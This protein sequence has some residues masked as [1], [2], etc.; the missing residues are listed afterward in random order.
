MECY[1][2]GLRLHS[3][4]SLTLHLEGPRTSKLTVI[5]KFLPLWHVRSEPNWYSRS[6]VVRS[7]LVSMAFCVESHFAAPTFHWPLPHR[8]AWHFHANGTSP[9]FIQSSIFVT[10]FLSQRSLRHIPSATQAGQRCCGTATFAT[11]TPLI[12]RKWRFNRPSILLSLHQRCKLT[13]LLYRCTQDHEAYPFPMV[14]KS[15]V[16]GQLKCIV[17]GVPNCRP[18]PAL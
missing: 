11:P 18:S 12:H 13:V 2:Q 6:K 14:F 10:F 1:C 9:A 17:S 15:F 7:S 16:T 5:W 3:R 8:R 4:L